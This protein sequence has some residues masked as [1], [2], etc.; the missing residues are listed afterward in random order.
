MT[1]ISAN[2]S[3][4]FSTIEPWDVSNSVANLGP[5]AARLTWENAVCVA[6]THRTWL[7]TSLGDASDCM[8]DWAESTGAWSDDEIAAAS[9]IECLALFVQ[10][11]AS[12][13]RDYLGADDHEFAECARVYAETD[14]ELEGS[15]PIGMYELNE[16]GH[17]T[18]DY[19]TGI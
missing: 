9:D 14:W 10:N 7:T 18:V 4:M 2:V 16:F 5:N 8:R 11:V 19:Y 13:L 15:Y 6:K 17:L 12:E 1:T 3:E